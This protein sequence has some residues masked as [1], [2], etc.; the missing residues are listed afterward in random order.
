[1]KIFEPEPETLKG[2]LGFDILGSKIGATYAIPY[3]DGYIRVKLQNPLGDAKY[4]SPKDRI[5]KHLYYLPSEKDNLQSCKYSVILTEG[6]YRYLALHAL[7]ACWIAFLKAWLF[8]LDSL[9]ALLSLLVLLFPP[10]I[11]LAFA[12]PA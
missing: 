3:A 12:F 5:G 2:I 4:L 1:M 8:C 6:A 7:Q 11:Q 10:P 9:P